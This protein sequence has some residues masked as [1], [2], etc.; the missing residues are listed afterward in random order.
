MSKHSSPQALGLGLDCASVCESIAMFED[1]ITEP[2]ER[3]RVAKHLEHTS[4]VL[5]QAAARFR[6]SPS[7]AVALGILQRR[8]PCDS[9]S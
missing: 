5:A 2:H 6:M 4:Q 8:H 1:V 3:F 9:R 7:A